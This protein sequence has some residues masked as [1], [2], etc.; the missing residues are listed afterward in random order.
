MNWYIYVGLAAGILTTAAF[1]PQAIKTLRTKK[2]RD[3]SLMMYI[4]VVAGLFLWLVYGILLKDLPLILANAITFLFS[5][6]ILIM[7]I[8]YGDK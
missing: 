4:M 5:V 6:F 1:L 7:K 3:I 2:T 8:R